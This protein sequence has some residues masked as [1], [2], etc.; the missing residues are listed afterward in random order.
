VDI[1]VSL[2]AHANAREYYQ[3]MKQAREKTEKTIAAADQALKS[4]EKKAHQTMKGMKICWSLSNC[5]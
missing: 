2:S 5:N 1:D 3:Q 4:A